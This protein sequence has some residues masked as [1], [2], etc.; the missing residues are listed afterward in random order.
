MWRG[1]LAALVAA[2]ALVS[3]GE[4]TP[5]PAPSPTP[6]TVAAPAATPT[7]E[8][9]A[10]LDEAYVLLRGG[11]YAEAAAVFATVAERATD[12]QLRSTA[13]LGEAV[14]AYDTGAHGRSMGLL[15]RALEA[16]THGSPEEARAVYLL[17]VRLNEA[18]AFEEAVAL[19]R[20]HSVFGSGLALGPS[21]ASEYARA[22]AGNGEIER[23]ET[24]WQSLLA[25]P[26]LG[27]QLRLPILR[28]RAAI[29]RVEDDLEGRRRW[30]GELARLTRDPEVRHELAAVGFLLGD[31]DLFEAQLRAIIAESPWTEEALFSL[32]DLRQA[33]Y[34]VDPGQE[35]FV[36][37]RHGAFA[38]ARVVLLPAV[39]DPAASAEELAYR[40][41]FLAA[42]YDDDGFYLESIPLYDA[43][44]AQPEAGVFA[45]RARYWAA[46]ALE[47][48]GRFDEA[49]AR[50]DAVAGETGAEFA[51]EAAFRSGFS[52]LRSGN[53]AGALEAWA[54]KDVV[55]AR[56]HYWR[57]RVLEDLGD[58]E[59]ARR[60]YLEAVALQ[61][62]AFHGIEARRALALDVGGDGR[63]R[64]LAPPP[65]PDWEGLAA[66]LATHRPGGTLREVAAEAPELARVGLRDRAAETI[67]LAAARTSDPWT[68]LSLARAATEA[69]LPEQVTAIAQRIQLILNLDNA[70][71][72]DPFARLRYPLPYPALLEEHG[73][74]NGLD[75]LF[76]AALIYQESRWNPT[77]VSV[78]NAVG[79]TQVIGPTAEWIAGQLGKGDVAPGELF[80]PAVSIEFGAY[81]LGVQLRE[82]GDPHPALAAYNAGP[83]NAELWSL[84]ASWP[85]ADFVE[86]I[87][88]RE[89]RAYVQLVM[90]HY[91]WYRAL[92]G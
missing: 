74:A 55:E 77:A 67:Q 54:A 18:R 33:G 7:P 24:V 81:Y 40:T 71:L 43:V 12:P 6:T 88:F 5:P 52:R 61:P 9:A 68:L 11:R 65:V 21:I 26:G 82:F 87:T 84:V 20:P 75:P 36:Y 50:Y 38:Q 53:V 90:E 10:L 25:T 37:Y 13:L 86:A 1:A 44:A 32:R 62:R 79:L 66:W 8:P 49:A 16:A 57:G 73:K 3:C 14:A 34:E 42:A 72:P 78:A 63:Y 59:E 39:Q 27:E 4:D 60:A 76:L 51:A 58:A 85:P 17:G 56:T 31:L 92:Y 23:A 15:R 80:R 48:A 19:L 22:L 30:L 91:A 41:Y 2:L 35:G 89:T 64:R 29:A 45:H 69:G 47:N 46:R 83:S 28:Q 70:A